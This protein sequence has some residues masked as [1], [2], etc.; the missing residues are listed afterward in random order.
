MVRA[1]SVAKLYRLSF[2]YHYLSFYSYF[3]SVPGSITSF[4]NHCNALLNYFPANLLFCTLLP[5]LGFKD[6]RKPS[7]HFVSLLTLPCPQ[8]LQDK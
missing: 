5:E 4:L 8:S 6:I 2:C 1:Q 7:E 3:C